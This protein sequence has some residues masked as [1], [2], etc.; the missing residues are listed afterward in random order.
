VRQRGKGGGCRPRVLLLLLAGAAVPQV[1]SRR[2]WC[3]HLGC[4]SRAQQGSLRPGRTVTQGQGRKQRKEI[5]T[6]EQTGSPLEVNQRDAHLGIT[7]YLKH[8]AIS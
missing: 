2:A 1:N 8:L 5:P 3:L 7:L 4:N 6:H